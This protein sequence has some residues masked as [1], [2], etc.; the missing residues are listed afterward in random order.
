MRRRRC[1]GTYAFFLSRLPPVQLSGHPGVVLT[2]ECDVL[3]RPLASQSRDPFQ[4]MLVHPVGG[5]VG[6]QPLSVWRWVVVV[7][8]DTHARAGGGGAGVH[9]AA[10]SRLSACQHVS[11][12]AEGNCRKLFTEQVVPWKYDVTCPSKCDDGVV[13]C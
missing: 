5:Q 13:R 9:C 12:V 2:V 10:A 3:S 4:D 6:G 11:V 8:S 1:G 7:V